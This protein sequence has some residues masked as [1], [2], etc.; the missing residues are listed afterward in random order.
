VFFG[1]ADSD[2]RILLPPW[3]HSHLERYPAL[4]RK[5]EQGEMVGVSTA[6]AGAGPR[7]VA[8][9]RSN[10]I[11]I[12]VIRDAA[13]AAV[14][15]LAS[16]PDAPTLSAEEIE[17]AR[18]FAYDAAPILARMQE[19]ERLRAENAELSSKAERTSR[20]EQKASLLAEERKVLNAILQMHTHQQV[21]VAHELRTP[22]AAI[23]GYV[24]MIIDGRAGVINE[25]QKEYLQIATE[26]TNRL[27]ALVSWMSHVAELS[28]QH[29]KPSTFDFRDIWAKCVEENQ[30]RLAEKSLKLSQQIAGEPFT[31]FGD[32]EK[33]AYALDELV[34]IAVKLADEG[35]TIAAELTHGREGVLQ[36][37]LMEK[38]ADIPSEVLR[39]IFERSFESASNP[40]APGAISLSGVYDVV[41]MHGGRVFVNSSAGQGA[42]FLFTLPVV[43]AGDE[44]DSHDEAVHSGRRRR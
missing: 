17:E 23:R 11:L 39:R 32:C 24:R 6:D 29:F 14:I 20:A 9:A 28:A 27:I 12:P 30:A 34:A 35:G 15:V 25:K 42:T 44:E 19:L 3:L 41:G 10:A 31:M 13:L 33:L 16:S 22:L 5:L 38:G 40:A 43:A 4:Y 21:N 2:S 8:G 36:F 18:L 37:K 1:V 7:P 26:N